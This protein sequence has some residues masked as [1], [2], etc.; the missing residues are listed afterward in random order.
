MKFGMIILSPFHIRPV[1]KCGNINYAK[2]KENTQQSTRVNAELIQ[3]IKSLRTS[4]L[5][6]KLLRRIR[7]SYSANCERKIE[8]LKLRLHIFDVFNFI[9]PFILNNVIYKCQ[10]DKEPGLHSS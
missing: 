6:Q 8:V 4:A 9:I 10:A 1:R 2:K 3:D 5:V 7:L